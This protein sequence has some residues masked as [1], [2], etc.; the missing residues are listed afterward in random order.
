LSWQNQ[1]GVREMDKTVIDKL[2]VAL[3][4]R[5]LLF[6]ERAMKIVDYED[7]NFKVDFS[8][9]GSVWNRIASEYEFISEEENQQ[10]G[11]LPKELFEWEE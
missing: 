11:I 6:S 8:D 9:L 1:Y 3:K 2:D 7:I 4:Q 10:S 5:M